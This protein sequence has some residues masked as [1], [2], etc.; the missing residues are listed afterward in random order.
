[1]LFTL[2]SALCATA[3]NIE[4]LVAFRMLQG[5]GGGLL[6][7]VGMM[8]LT[9]AAGP[10]RMGSVM[11][12]LGIPMLLGPICGPILGGL[13]IEQLSWHWIFLI[14]LPIGIIALVYAWFVLDS[15]YEASRE[16]IDVLGLLLLSPAWPCSC[17]ASP[18]A[19]RRAPSPPRGC[20]CPPVS[21]SC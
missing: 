4:M 6:M 16:S 17:T 13:L 5:L 2:G 11:A 3:V 19:P 18:A 21:A 7:P 20:C 10:A 15:E 1:M 8:I 12:A 9:K 14:N